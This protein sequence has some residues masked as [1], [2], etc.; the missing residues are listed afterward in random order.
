MNNDDWLLIVFTALIM[1]ALGGFVGESCSKD[2]IR[3]DA[4]RNGVAE[5]S[6]NENGGAEFKWKT[7]SS[8][9]S[10]KSSEEGK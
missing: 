9:P 7:N 1:F 6:A 8:T 5:W 10:L 2:S 4:I 3:R